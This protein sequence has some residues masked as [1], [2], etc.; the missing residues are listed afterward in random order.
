MEKRHEWCDPLRKQVIYKVLIERDTGIVDG[1]IAS[2]DGY[3]S[4]PGY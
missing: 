1:I 2:T 3:D 4:A